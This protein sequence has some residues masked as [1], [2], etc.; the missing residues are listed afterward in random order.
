M[1][2]RDRLETCLAQTELNELKKKIDGRMSFKETASH[3]NIGIHML[4]E[5]HDAGLLVATTDGLDQRPKFRRES[6]ES[7]VENLAPKSCDIPVRY[8]DLSP[9][10]RAAARVHCRTVEIIE[11]VLAGKLDCYKLQPDKTDI[12]SILSLIHI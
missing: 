7:F 9:L 10:I 8:D 2:I 4:E 5:F 1:C 11:L 3:L 6:I 12:A